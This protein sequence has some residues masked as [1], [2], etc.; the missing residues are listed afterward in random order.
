MSRQLLN[1]YVCV[2]IVITV[3]TQWPQY[4]LARNLYVHVYIYYTENNFEMS[5]ST[6]VDYNM[7]ITSAADEW[8]D[9][10]GFR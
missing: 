5:R 8:N 7:Y 3:L 10:K 1:D 9:I 4:D 2:I 6:S